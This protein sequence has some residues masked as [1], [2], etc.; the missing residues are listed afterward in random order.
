[1]AKA[2]GA[3]TTQTLVRRAVLVLDV[4]DRLYAATESFEPLCPAL[5]YLAPAILRGTAIEVIPGDPDAE[6]LV[7]ALEE[8]C[9]KDHSVWKHIAFDTAVNPESPGAD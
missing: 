1:M 3:L 4:Y 2:T 8:C 9:P 5:A 6:A 7:A